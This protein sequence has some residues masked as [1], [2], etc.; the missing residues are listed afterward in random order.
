MQQRSKITAVSVD[1]FEFRKIVSYDAHEVI[2]KNAVLVREINI[3]Y[4]C[5]GIMFI[6]NSTKGMWLKSQAI[7]ATPV[8]KKR[9]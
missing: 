4:D 9:Q 2:V 6:F 3:L 5:L 8:K 7:Q 1:F